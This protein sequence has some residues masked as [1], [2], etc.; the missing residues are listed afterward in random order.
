MAKKTN[1]TINGKEYYRI[2]RKVGMKVNKLGIWVDDRRSF[3]GSCK[4]EAE[5][6]YQ[7][8]MERKKA[9]AVSD[10]CLG[11]LIDQYIEDVFK[12]CD[13]ANSTKAKYI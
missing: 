4:K 11:Q 6:K 2:Y 10:R 9:G 3:Y 7:E 1:C 12:I 13:L 5:E 8:F